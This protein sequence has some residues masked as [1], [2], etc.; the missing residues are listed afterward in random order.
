MNYQK[1]YT[2]AKD[3]GYSDTEIAQYLGGEKYKE[4]KDSG[5]SDQEIISHLTD[6]APPAPAEPS[7]VDKFKQVA[8]MGVQAALPSADF[9][10]PLAP[11]SPNPA[12]AGLQAA[13]QTL[14]DPTRLSSTMAQPGQAAG[15]GIEVA[16]GPNHP[17][18][19]KVANVAAS[20]ALDP[21]TYTLGPVGKT[22]AGLVDKTAQVA[23]EK[24]LAPAGEVLSATRIKDIKRLFTNPK[25]VLFAPSLA[26]S[27]K[28]MGDVE[29][30]LGVTDD[31][32]RLIAKAGDRATGGSRTVVEGLIQ[33]GKDTAIAAG[34][35]P[36]NWAKHLTPGELIAGRRGASKLSAAAKGR[37]SYIAVQD[38]KAFETAFVE[39]AKAKA[40]TYLKAVK[41]QAN[42]RT[43]SVFMNVLPLNKNLSH[44][45]LRGMAAA[46]AALSGN[47]LMAIAMSP[48]VTGIG[49]LAAKGAYSAGRAVASNPV[50]TKAV[51]AGT[52]AAIR[53]FLSKTAGS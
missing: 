22:A 41:D 5:Y 28:V 20:I 33:K 8:K 14:R 25:E 15:R 10:K 47:P 13:A 35:K 52:L 24:V 11:T 6:V 51:G 32:A 18:L 23:G 26:K 49:T 34:D 42:A 1:A 37:E 29:K 9:D 19:G 39:T 40:L 36:E 21:S 3:Q 45:A 16:I 7:L 4:A 12:I 27:G 2:E 30:A 17:I 50:S 44:N 48:A 31:E 46:G 38:V 53:A 43:R